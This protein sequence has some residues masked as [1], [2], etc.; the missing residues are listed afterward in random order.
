MPAPILEARVRARRYW[1]R[2]GLIE[3]VVGIVVLLM[4]GECLIVALGQRKATGYLL[5]YAVSMVAVAVLVPR[6]TAVVR[7]RVT[8]PRSGYAHSGT[9]RRKRSIALIIVGALLLIAARVLASHRS[10]IGW[11]YARWLP[12]M[13]GVAIG[14]IFV[15]E[16]RRL[17]LSRLLAVGVLS[18]ILGIAVCIAPPLA[19]SPALAMALYLAGLG[20]ALLCSGGVTLRNYLRS[21]PPPADQI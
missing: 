15:Y 21:A 2:D 1:Y 3:I 4:S 9:S 17:R 16:S 7:E 10:L 14:A 19:H 12:A 13:A 8:Y 20:C 18:I 5:G 6:V 11:D